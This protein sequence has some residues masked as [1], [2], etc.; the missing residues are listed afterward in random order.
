MKNLKLPFAVATLSACIL[1][2]CG[3]GSGGSTPAVT[4]TSTAPRLSTFITDDLAKDYAKVWVGILDITLIDAAGTKTNIFKV[5]QPAV[6]NL[7][8]LASVAQ[9]MSS[10]TVPKGNYTKALVTLDDKV[11]LTSLDGKTTINAVF[12]GD[13]SA[14]VVPVDLDLDTGATTQLVLD[15]DL[16]K[17]TYD[18]VTN[19]VTPVVLKSNKKGGDNHDFDR[20]QAEAHGVVTSIDDKGLVINDKHLGNNVRINV[21]TATDIIGEESEKPIA[22]KDIAVGFRIEAHGVLEAG[23]AAPTINARLVQ[24]E[25]GANNNTDDSRDNPANHA[26]GVGKV[27][28]VS[29][30]QITV[31][32]T[33][34][35][36]LPGAANIVIDAAKAKFAHGT[37]A[38]IKVGNKIVF[39]GKLTGTTV[40]ATIIDVAGALS[41]NERGEHGNGQFADIRGSV[42]AVSGAVAELKLDINSQQS[43]AGAPASLK[44]DLSKAQFERGTLSCV[45]VGKVLEVAGVLD[46]TQFIAKEAELEHGCDAPVA[47]K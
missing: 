4:A 28:A 29:G 6:Y 10:V 21:G 43:L 42:T 24:V 45:V 33:D 2:A 35:N 7:S 46:A 39:H 12:K 27:V 31:S 38:D 41:R 19:R 34:A 23:T 36:F 15:F 3:G 47:T 40:A 26:K 18:A 17:F 37:L 5:P 44:V 9:L 14:T 1:V 8:S 32:V 25:S 11:Q 22:L 13:G 16:S 20:N 30:T